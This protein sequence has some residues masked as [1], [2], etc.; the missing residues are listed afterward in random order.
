MAKKKAKGDY[1]GL[2]RVISLIIAIFLPASAICGIVT[3]FQEGKV[4]AG[5][6]RIFIGWNVMWVV[7]LISMILTKKIF[8]LLN[9]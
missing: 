1:F 6:I 8:R 2:G 5:I 9:M 7:D 3:R 4:V